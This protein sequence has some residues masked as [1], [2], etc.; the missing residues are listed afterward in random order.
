MKTALKKS[1]VLIGIALFFVL[2]AWAE[3]LKKSI[4]SPDILKK[5]V[6]MQRQYMVIAFVSKVFGGLSVNS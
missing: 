2:T 4:V 1:F 6:K 3:H 5:T